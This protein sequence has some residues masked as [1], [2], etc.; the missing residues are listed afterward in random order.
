MNQQVQVGKTATALNLGYALASMNKKV[1]LIDLDPKGQLSNDCDLESVTS[2]IHQVLTDEK[3]IEEVKHNLAK[4]F[5]F[6]AAGQGLINF[7]KVTNST[8][9]KQQSF[10]L[11]RAINLREHQEDFILIDCPAKLGLLTVNALLAADE[12]VITT[13][14]NYASLQ[15]LTRIVS[16]FKRLKKIA[17]GAKLWLVLTQTDQKDTMMIEVKKRV[18]SCFPRRVFKTDIRQDEQL[19]TSRLNKQTIFDYDQGSMGAADYFSLAQDLI[20]GRVN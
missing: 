14:S 6:I 12:I 16:L 1:T 8:E 19:I 9:K 4:G 18:I 3:T 17:G 11:K 2:G 7:E 5:D 13:R 15:G 20:E 10:Q